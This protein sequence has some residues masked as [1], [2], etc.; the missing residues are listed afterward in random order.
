MKSFAGIVALAGLAS[1]SLAQ[2]G[3][4][5]TI[6]DGDTSFTLADYTGNGTGNG[7]NADFSVDTSASNTDHMYQAWWWFRVAGDS[8]ETTFSGATSW[9]WVGNVG[10]LTY[11]YPQFR[12]VIQYVVTGVEPGLGFVTQTCT[13]FNTTNQP[14]TI[15]L[16]NYQDLDMAETSS[17]D[18]ANQSG[19]NVMSVVDGGGTGWRA[20]YEGTNAFQVSSFA[21][22]LNI[23]TDANADNLNGTGL[24]FGP[25][26]WTGG[27]QWSF[28]L[29]PL[30]AAT[31]SAT[32]TIIPAPGALALMG[33][34]GLVAGRRRR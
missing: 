27:Y 15:D 20:E 23:L 7:P 28:T 30:S 19:A 13:I 31:A 32:V 26:D 4:G 5:G 12:A 18:S 6:T 16:F 14:L 34:G 21:N 1:V 24:P 10:R 3:S 33:L 11:N 25:G 9:S 29:M 8:R 22:L 17:D 2:V